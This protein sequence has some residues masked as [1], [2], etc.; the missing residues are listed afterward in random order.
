MDVIAD[1]TRRVIATLGAAAFQYGPTEGFGPL[2]E[3]LADSI[4]VGRVINRAL[5]EHT[6]AL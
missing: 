4:A 1:I 2:R 6:A 5:L 3:A